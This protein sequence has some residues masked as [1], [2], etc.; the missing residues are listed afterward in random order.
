MKLSFSDT[1]TSEQAGDQFGEI[2]L[3]A[4][5]RAISFDPQ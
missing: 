1:I 5:I 4:E 3:F 2:L